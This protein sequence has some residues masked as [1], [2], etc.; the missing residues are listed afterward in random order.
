MI[1]NSHDGQ[2]GA[3]GEPRPTRRKTMS[4]KQIAANQL[5]AQKSTGPK[6]A[7]GKAVS[8][9]NALKHGVLAK[10]VVVRGHHFQESKRGFKKL[11]QEL[12]ASL[13][14]VEPL[15]AMLVDQIATAH[16]RLRRVRMAEAGEIALSVDEVH[17]SRSRVNPRLQLMLWA[18][19]NDPVWEMNGSAL[20]NSVLA[21]K[22]S[23]VRK[24]VEQEGELTEAAIKDLLFGARNTISE[25][26]EK[27]RARSMPVPEGM[28]AAVHREETKKQALAHIDRKLRT[29]AWQETE[30]KRRED[31]EA[32]S[33]QA[34][35]ALPPEE[36]L[37]KILRYEA[38]LERQLF[39]AMNQLERL[40][41]RRLGEAVPP[42][43]AL[44]VSERR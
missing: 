25:D 27:L 12:Y 16:W 19:R 38:A 5:N 8:K 3:H 15:E 1:T 4:L 28:D 17:N 40:Q 21:L 32:Q 37:E 43:L 23:E 7:A 6:T 9:M 18:C 44:E 13:A 39:R 24:Q 30:C 35:A 29:L 34:A 36:A 26:L 41:R 10:T 31:S 11:C 2:N 33:R 42:P 20:G 22:L 14:P